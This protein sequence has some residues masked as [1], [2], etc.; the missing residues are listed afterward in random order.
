MAGIGFPDTASSGEFAPDAAFALAATGI[1]RSSSV[2]TM[3]FI[4]LE[5]AGA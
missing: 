1:A 4:V 2:K 5:T 3:T